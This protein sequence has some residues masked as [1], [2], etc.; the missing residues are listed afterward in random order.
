M[1]WLYL[2]ER[3]SEQLDRQ[4]KHV[5]YAALGLDD[6]R[7]SSI[8]LKLA[9]KPKYLHIDAAVEH[10]FMNARC[11][12]E[13]LSAE[14]SLWR[15]EERDQES[16]LALCQR[17]WSAA[18]VCQASRAAI[19]LPTA[20]SV[21]TLLGLSLRGDATRLPRAQHG[22]NA[23]KKFPKTKWFGHIVI[24]AK[25]QPD[26]AVNL[27][28]SM[29]GGDDYRHVGMG[30]DLTQQVETIFLTKLKVEDHHA[31]LACCELPHHLLSL[32]GCDGPHIVVFKV[33]HEHV[34]Y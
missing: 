1:M 18:R 26:H 11:L 15:I 12:Q 16:V 23:R 14:W 24:G 17:D 19:E 4:G 6:T 8:S 21:A 13:V 33:V 10:V 3:M 34:L 5:T 30:A 27:V 9:S 20:K 32:R 28:A 25:F 22:P 29:T 31:G 7:H 2:T